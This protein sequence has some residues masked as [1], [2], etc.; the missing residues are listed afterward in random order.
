MQKVTKAQLRQEVEGMLARLMDVR[1]GKKESDMN[2]WEIQFLLAAFKRVL[3]TTI[4]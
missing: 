1:L 3:Q 2:E 4:K